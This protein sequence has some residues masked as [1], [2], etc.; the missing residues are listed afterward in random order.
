[1]RHHLIYLLWCITSLGCSSA[2]TT[3]TSGIIS[4]HPAVTETIF[5]LNAGDQLS[6]RS[7]YCG[8]PDAAA[9]LPVFGTALTPNIEALASA[10]PRL[11]IVVTSDQTQTERIGEVAS[12]L[13]L[14][15]LTTDDIVASTRQLGTHIHRVNEANALAN[16]YEATLTSA[17][18]D[19][20]PTAV[21]LLGNGELT[22]KAL[23]YI[24]PDS[25]HG[26]ALA[27]A[28]FRNAME[29]GIKG[30]PSVSIESLIAI[31]PDVIIVLT[32]EE[33]Q[34]AIL[35]SLTPIKPL[36]AIQTEQLFVVSGPHVMGNGLG[37]LTLVDQ[38]RELSIQGSK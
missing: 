5:A 9:E 24:K 37:I 14:P 34:A 2:P 28:G 31:N 12:T 17:I 36:R 3:N 21:M 23:W 29:T 10:Q 6:G 20:A 32:T 18:P 30:A 1:M 16:Q 27:A 15:W 13:A 26:S 7:Q 33:N 19:N 8:T 25:I 4:L 38:L 11:V 35:S 22:H